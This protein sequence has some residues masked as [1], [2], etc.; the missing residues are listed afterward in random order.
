MNN[1]SKIENQVHAMQTNEIFLLVG[2][3][4]ARIVSSFTAAA[5]T[6][7]SSSAIAAAQAPFA[8]FVQNPWWDV[9]VAREEDGSVETRGPHLSDTLRSLCERSASLLRDSLSPLP[10]ELEGVVSA[11]RIGRIVGMFEQNNVGVRAPSP[12]PSM[13]TEL[14]A[15]GGESESCVVKEASSL[16]TRVLSGTDADSE[17]CDDDQDEES[18]EAEGTD[19]GKLERGS[20]GV[21]SCDSSPVGCSDDCNTSERFMGKIGV[22]ATDSDSEPDH[23]RVLEEA[24]DVGEEIFAPLDGTA[25]YTLVCSMNHSCRPNCVVKYPGR[26]RRYGIGDAR[27]D[28]LVAQVV[29]LD[30]VSAGEE[31]TQS[32]ISVDMDIQ[33]R[34]NALEDYGFFCKCPRCLEEEDVLG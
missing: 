13:L 30:N 16:V 17:C 1:A 23:T 24:V 7:P 32:Y 15:L 19:E 28:P 3:V 25:L 6:G 2:E 4:V 33:E 22:A 27:A 20:C 34:R 21:G 11:E 12:L 10:P 18:I 31:L 8:D 14:I 5:A 9:A 29:L 26:L